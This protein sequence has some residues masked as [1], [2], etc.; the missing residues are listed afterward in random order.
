MR[1]AI[2]PLLIATALGMMLVLSGCVVITGQSSQQLSTIG[3]VRLTTTACFS[4]TSGCPDKGN[5]NTAATGGGFQVVVGYRVPEDT[6]VPQAFNSTAGQAL[7]LNRDASYS[8]E[9][10]RLAPAG[11]GLKWVGYRSAALTSAPSAPTFTVS[12][13]FAL[14]Q[15]PDG[16]PFDGPFAYRVVTGARATPSNPNAS[17]D[18]GSNLAGSQA[19]K[20]TCVDSPAVS[21]VTTSLQQPT[22]D[23]GIIDDPTANRA[24]R[25]KVEPV[26]FRIVYAGK[27]GSAPTFDLSA[28]TDVPGAEANP[29]PAS[30]TPIAG[31]TKVRVNL[32]LP[33]DTTRGSYD[34]TLLAALPNGQTRSRTQEVQIGHVSAPCGTANP[35][36]T[37]TPGPDRLVGTRGRD[38]ISAYGG[39]DR[40]LGRA[41]ND[42][43]CAGPGD[44]TVNGGAG[45]DTIAGRG[46][47]DHLIG[48]RG[49][50]LMIGGPGKDSFKH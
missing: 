35:T 30:L 22:Q 6:S 50:D 16:E 36:I 21:E 45:N 13:T 43:I 34:V 42:L 48:G 1:R 25:G 10:E 7:S 12:P 39:N 20:T 3:A 27:A 40:I 9:L 5:S 49:H 41:G 44:D 4:Q 37:G 19:S 18:C 15:G 23:L 32:H 31:A 38:V 29:R 47:K 17:V 11:A 33:P 2:K 8:A 28:S 26:Q 46:G 24:S 14:R